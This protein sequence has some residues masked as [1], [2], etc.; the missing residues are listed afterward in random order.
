[1]VKKVAPKKEVK[2]VDAKAAAKKE[3]ER[4]KKIIEKEIKRAK[5]EVS[6]AEKNVVSYIKKNP[7][8]AAAI[9]AGVGVAIGAAITALLKSNKK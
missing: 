3:A 4:A 1:M 9:S 2:K 5:K 7:E 6:K 8:Q